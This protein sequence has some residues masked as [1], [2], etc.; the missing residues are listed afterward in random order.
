MK[1]RKRIKRGKA[2]RTGM[3]KKCYTEGKGK[4]RKRVKGTGQGRK[5]WVVR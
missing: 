3:K 2:R 5:S 4:E 1:K